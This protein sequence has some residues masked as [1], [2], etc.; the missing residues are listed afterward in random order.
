MGVPAVV[1]RIRQHDDG[2]SQIGIDSCPIEGFDKEAVETLLR[3]EGVVTGDDFGLAC[4]AAFGYRI[5][6]PR[7][8]TRRP[9]DQV[10]RWVL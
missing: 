6:E 4:M 8:K 9:L 7:D 3:A 1:Y 5:R 2:C 10:V